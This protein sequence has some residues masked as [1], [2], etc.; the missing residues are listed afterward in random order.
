MP[1]S[2]NIA[3]FNGVQIGDHAWVQIDTENE[4]EVH[5]IPRADGS[6]IRRRGGGLKTLTVHAWVK[7]PFRS[8]ISEFFD[9]LGGSLSSAVADLIVDDITYSNCL[10]KS[11]S[12]SG[13]HNLWARFTIVFISPGD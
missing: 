9:Q 13:E 4:I 1:I 10:M 8:E 12:Q 6:I 7:K 5:K 11:I 3:I 2:S